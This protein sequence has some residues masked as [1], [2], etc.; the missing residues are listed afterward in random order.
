MV[1]ISLIFTFI[2]AHVYK[3]IGVNKNMIDWI[4]KNVKIKENFTKNE[5][6]KG[7]PLGESQGLGMV[8][9]LELQELS[10]DHKDL[11]MVSFTGILV[12]C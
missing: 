9:K 10:I 8:D 2:K 5:C 6:Q 7:S 4:L 11:G 12:K 3:I 1:S